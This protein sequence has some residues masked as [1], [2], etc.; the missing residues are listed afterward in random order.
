M[1]LFVKKHLKTFDSKPTSSQIGLIQKT[2]PKEEQFISSFNELHEQLANGGVFIFNTDKQFRW[3]VVDIDGAKTPLGLALGILERNQ[4][5]PLLAYNTFSNGLNGLNRY[6]LLYFFQQP[7]SKEEI[8]KQYSFINKLLKLEKGIDK[9]F[10]NNIN[11]ICFGTNSRVLFFNNT[12]YKGFENLSVD[13]EEP[14]NIIDNKTNNKRDFWWL[15]V[16]YKVFLKQLNKILI[17]KQKVNWDLLIRWYGVNFG[18]LEI[19]KKI[20]SLAKEQNTKKCLNLY[21]KKGNKYVKV[22]IKDSQ[23]F[24]RLYTYNEK[25]LKKIS[26]NKK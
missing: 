12:I 18:N 25:Q 10:L 1:N 21:E 11:Q 9:V 5:L 16:E 17:E 13:I 23:N 2:W 26:K 6:R 19:R 20:I 24:T 7:I 8:K 4:I 14:K 22:L 3:V 15:E